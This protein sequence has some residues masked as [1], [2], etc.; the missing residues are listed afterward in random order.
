MGKYNRNATTN[1]H[2][3]IF[4]FIFSLIAFLISTI[5]CGGVSNFFTI[6]VS[7]HMAC[8]CFRLYN[9]CKKLRPVPCNNILLY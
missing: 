2:Y 3:M 6:E 9:G 4:D 8:F 7:T 5:I 1:L